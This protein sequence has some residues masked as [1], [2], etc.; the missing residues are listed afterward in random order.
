MSRPMGIIQSSTFHKWHQRPGWWQ[1]WGNH[2]GGGDRAQRRSGNGREHHMGSHCLAL[3]CLALHAGAC[4]WDPRPWGRYCG[5][6]TAAPVTWTSERSKCSDA[7]EDAG[8]CLLPF[9]RSTAQTAE[10][11]WVLSAS[12]HQVLS[13]SEGSEDASWLSMVTPEP[14][15]V[16]D[17]VCT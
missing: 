17:T 7:R 9:P 15:P 5:R 10:A 4:H 2:K 14:S 16:P 11:A 1:S 13:F 12:L 8:W 3:P 6:G